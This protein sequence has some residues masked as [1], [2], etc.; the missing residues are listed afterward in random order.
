[1][2]ALMKNSILALKADFLTEVSTAGRKLRTMFDARVKQ[3][4]LTL[5]RARA[6]LFL[7]KAKCMTQT[8]LAG[9]LEIETPTLVRLLDGL[10]KQGLVERNAVDGDRRAKH[11]TLTDEA[12]SQVRE[13][14]EMTNELREQVLRDINEDDLAAGIRIL[15]LMLKN[16][17]AMNEGRS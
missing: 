15:R 11:I 13:I 12:L 3:R 1:M 6:M 9:A 17:E 4:G 16:I 5:S 14:D 7:S 10:E 8:E 2:C